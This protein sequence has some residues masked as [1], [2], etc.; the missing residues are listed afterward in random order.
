MR[1]V[2][3]VNQIIDRGGDGL[4]LDDE[5]R[6]YNVCL[7]ANRYA[8]KLVDLANKIV[9]DDLREAVLDFLANSGIT[10]EDWDYTLQNSAGETGW[11][12]VAG[13]DEW[14]EV[15]FGQYLKNHDI[16]AFDNVVN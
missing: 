1:A 7:P 8:K 2:D 9:D 15:S 3:N 13:M 12:A 16:S 14:G 4:F 6:I 5:D 11:D 10:E